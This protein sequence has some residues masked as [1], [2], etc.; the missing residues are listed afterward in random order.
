MFNMT[1]NVSG[2]STVALMA[3]STMVHKYWN[4]FPHFRTIQENLVVDSL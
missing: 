3:Y 2:E 1:E 4:W